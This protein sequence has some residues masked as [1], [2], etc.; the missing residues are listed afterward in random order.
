MDLNEITSTICSFNQDKPWTIFL[1][2]LIFFSLRSYCMKRILDSFD[3]DSLGPIPWE[4]LHDLCSSY[5]SENYKPYVDHIFE[6]EH[7]EEFENYEL[8]SIYIRNFA[9]SM[10]ELIETDDSDTQE[11]FVDYLDNF[12]YEFFNAQLK[13]SGILIFP[14]TYE[15]DNLRLEPYL[16]YI[17]FLESQKPKPV[18]TSAELLATPIEEVEVQK[19]VSTIAVALARRRKQFMYTKKK[20]KVLKRKNPFSQTIRLNHK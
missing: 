6:V 7:I 12:L 5:C 8:C 3:T 1:T 14:Q 13:E 9:E 4:T 2:Q 11:I 20:E 16:I 18:E 15:D 10:D 19:E 17:E